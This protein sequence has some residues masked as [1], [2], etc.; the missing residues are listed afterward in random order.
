[1]QHKHAKGFDN[2]PSCT[3]SYGDLEP[4][5]TCFSCGYSRPLR[6]TLYSLLADGI[7]DGS[8]PVSFDKL[9]SNSLTLE[10]KTIIEKSLQNYDQPVEVLARNEY[11]PHMI[12][13]L[14]SKGI[15]QQVARAFN[16]CYVPEGHADEWIGEDAEGNP[17]RVPGEGVLI[18]IMAKEGDSFVCVGAQMRMLRSGKFRYFTI[19]KYHAS[20]RLFGE[21]VLAK[22]VEKDVVITEGPFDAMHLVSLGVHS[23][24]LLGTVLNESK[25]EIIKQSGCGT[26]HLLLDPDSAGQKGSI[27]AGRML[28]KYGLPY[29]QHKAIKDP[30]FYTKQ[31]IKQLIK[32]SLS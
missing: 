28:Q 23:V 32:N 5:V 15:P 22:A 30:K 18:P 11:P 20:D 21:Q 1:M 27:K 6:D 8:L 12:E 9:R 10:P 17:K 26:I 13:F 19:Y 29:I 4:W 14:N 3:V 24:G 25:A 31:E 2:K 16:V 7:I